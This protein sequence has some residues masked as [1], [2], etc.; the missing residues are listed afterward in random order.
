METHVCGMNSGI[1]FATSFE[2]TISKQYHKNIIHLSLSFRF[3]ILKQRLTFV[4]KNGAIDL[5]FFY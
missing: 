5:I 4:Y 2:S 3:N 1:Q